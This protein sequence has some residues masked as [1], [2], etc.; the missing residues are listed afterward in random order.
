MPRRITKIILK[1][2]NL[3]GINH[4]MR[5][6]EGSIWGLAWADHKY[7]NVI[8]IGSFRNKVAIF[9]EING[10]WKEIAYH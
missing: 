1:S 5:S 6:D 8:R 10:V 9:Q 4:N 7:G 3:K 2:V